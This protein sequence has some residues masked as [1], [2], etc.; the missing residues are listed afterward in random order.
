MP[1][2]LLNENSDG[3]M[4][5]VQNT[6]TP[7]AILYEFRLRFEVVVELKLST[8]LQGASLLELPLDSHEIAHKSCQH[9]TLEAFGEESSLQLC[10]R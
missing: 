5:T 3:M 8:L 1:V 7:E 6:C 10:L 2:N 9:T 4:P